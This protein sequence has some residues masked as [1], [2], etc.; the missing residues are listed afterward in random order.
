V[1]RAA[2]QK[3]MMF[4]SSLIGVSKIGAEQ[5]LHTADVARP[6]LR[7]ALI[8]LYEQKIREEKDDARRANL[9]GEIE[10]LFNAL[11]RDLHKPIKADTVRRHFVGHWHLIQPIA[12]RDGPLFD[13]IIAEL[14]EA[15]S[16]RA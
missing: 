15:L 6:R 2:Q 5:H 14:H 10:A 8:D 16:D 7:M 13:A 4:N 11:R 9:Q 3:N 1:A 12:D